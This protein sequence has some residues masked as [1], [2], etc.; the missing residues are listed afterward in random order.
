M[1]TIKLEEGTRDHIQRVH[2]LP[3]AL[4]PDIVVVEIENITKINNINKE[5]IESKII[6]KEDPILPEKR[7]I[8]DIILKSTTSKA[9]KDMVKDKDQT[10]METNLMNPEFKFVGEIIQTTTVDNSQEFINKEI[11]ITNL[12][13]KDNH[14]IFK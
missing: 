11:M 12:N 9:E 3:P 2:L 4:D 5:D 14:N 10:I 6:M 7:K 1:M 8:T 13:K